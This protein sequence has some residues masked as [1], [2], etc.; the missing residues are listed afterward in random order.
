MSQGCK[1]LFV[2]CGEASGETYTV[3]VVREFRKRFPDAPVSG[4]GGERLRAEGVRLVADYA[5]ISVVGV[6]EV[7]RHL[8][9]VWKT[10]R[11]AIREATRPEVGAVLLVDFPDFNFLVGKRAAAKKVPVVYYIPPQLWAWRKGR[12]KQLAAFTRGVVVPFPFELET[13][14]AAGVNAR[15]AGHPLLDELSPFFDAAPAPGKF[16]IPAGSPVVGLLPGSR[17]GEIEKL[18]PPM[19]EAAKRIEAARPDIRFAVP[20]AAPRFRE[21]I[22]GILS[23]AGLEATLVDSDR[24]LLFRSMIAAISASGTATLELALLGVPSVIVYRTSNISYRIG[25]RLVSIEC[26]GLPNIIA[27]EPFLPELIQD[28]CNPERM[29]NELI[30]MISDPVKLE[31]M[32][33][34]C[35]ALRDKLRGDG[36]TRSVVDM[37]VEVSEGAW[38]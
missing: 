32:S 16:G 15:F 21:T 34:R 11:L 18:F 24:H 23:E 25:R 28:D 13:L 3:N 29:A 1:S 35:I 7:V 12:A 17:S 20:V 31:N 9:E 14:I 37:L 27:G 38:I 33:G 36:P 2:V 30:G 8:P 5:G 26:I 10:L 4:I 6:T 22:A 19:V